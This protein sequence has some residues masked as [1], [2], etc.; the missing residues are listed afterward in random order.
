[1]HESSGSLS[2]SPRSALGGLVPRTERTALGGLVSIAEGTVLGELV[3]RAEHAALSGLPLTS[4]ALHDFRTHELRI[5]HD[6]L[7][8]P[9]GRFVARVSASIA[10]TGRLYRSRVDFACR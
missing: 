6:D 1:M 3:P 8:A 4:T 7:S 10:T 9:P 2:W 5:R